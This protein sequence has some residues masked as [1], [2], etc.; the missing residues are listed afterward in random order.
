MKQGVIEAS[1]PPTTTA[2]PASRSAARER[3]RPAS[4]PVSPATA[5][6]G[7]LQIIDPLCAAGSRLVAIMPGRCPI[8]AILARDV[9]QRMPGRSDPVANAEWHAWLR[10]AQP[11]SAGS[12]RRSCWPSLLGAPARGAAGPDAVLPAASTC[13][14]PAPATA[15]TPTIR[16]T[17]RS[18]PAAGAWTTEFGTFYV[19]NITPDRETG[20][21]GW[22]RRG[23]P[24]RHD[25]GQDARRQPLLPGVPVPLVHRHVG[26]GPRRH[27]GL[28]AIGAA[29]SQPRAGARPPVPVQ[30]ARRCCSA[31]S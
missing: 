12:E 16:T 22:T 18:S 24:P 31:G 13:S 20:I 21:G 14:T 10:R 11:G 3:P 5:S 28:S 8:V 26:A 2:R 25:R 4:A 1:S 19:P 23:L 6:G 9:F 30:P 27:V 15:A 7:V 29:R 17:A